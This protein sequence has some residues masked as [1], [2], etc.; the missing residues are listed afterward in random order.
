MHEYSMT[1]RIVNS[2]L[3]EA[4]KHD[5]KRVSEVYLIIGKLTFLGL[6]QVRFAYN[7]LVKDTI[8]EDS[9]LYIEEK[10][11]V[12]Q[13]N[14]CGYRGDLQYK[15]DPVYHLP[16]PTVICP[17]CGGVVNI[18]EGKECILKRIKLIA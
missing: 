8:L 11:G 9:K 15:D 7:T 2:I 4:K 17:K 6:E 13:C 1:M 18:V 14:I 12:V 10:D 16:A 5:A 3:E